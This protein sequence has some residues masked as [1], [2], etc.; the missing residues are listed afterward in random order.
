[1]ISIIIKFQVSSFPLLKSII[2][3]STLFNLL[4]SFAILFQKKK[5]RKN[6]TEIQT[7]EQKEEE[8]SS[9]DVYEMLETCTDV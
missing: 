3:D 6:K 9:F 1:M 5:R 7:S 2:I 8:K 4:Q